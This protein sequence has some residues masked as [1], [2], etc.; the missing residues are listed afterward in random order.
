MVPQC[1]HFTVACAGFAGLDK[2]A[3]IP[4]L[5]AFFANTINLECV[6]GGYVMM[7]A[8]DLLLDFSDFLREKFD[9]SSALGAHHV[10]MTAAV[11]LVLITGDAVVEGDFAGE[12]ATG[13]EFQRAVDSGETDARIG[14]LDQTVQFVGGEM[15]AGFEESS[16]NRVALLGL[17]QA[18]AFEM[19]PKNSLGF[20]DALRRDGRLIVDSFLQHGGRRGHLR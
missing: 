7:L 19:L 18:D 20:A 3:S 17:F 5:S 8:S 9:R 10:V 12:S 2:S 1:G 4:L 16:Q 6:A 11:V 14:F 13:E 15:F